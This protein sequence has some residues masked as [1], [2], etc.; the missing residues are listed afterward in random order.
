MSP[1]MTLRATGG[2]AEFVTRHWHTKC[3]CKDESRPALRF[4]NHL[5]NASDCMRGSEVPY[6]NFLG[7]D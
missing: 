1:E 3:A 6:A 4:A 2:F 5:Y 7:T